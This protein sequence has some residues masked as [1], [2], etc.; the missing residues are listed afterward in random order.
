MPSHIFTRLG[1]WDEC[2][3]SN[4]ASTSAARCYAPAAGITGHWDEELHGLDYLVYAYLQKGGNKLAK[5]QCDYVQKIDD[6]YPVNFKVAYAFAA[7]PS[8]YLLENKL[9]DE[10]AGLKL[11]PAK[12]P[13]KNFPWQEAI[14]HFT[15]LMGCVH[16]GRMDSAEV[17]LAAL[18]MAHDSLMKQKDLYKA[19]QVQIQIN[20]AKAWMELKQGNNDE[21]IKLMNMAADMEDQTEKNPVTPCEVLPARELLGDMLLQMNKPAESLQAYEADLKRHPKR[22]NGVY[23]AGLAAE[24]SGKI[25]E[26][27][28]YYQQLLTF[29]NT[30]TAD[31]Q[32]LI[33]VKEFLKEH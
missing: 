16:I 13:W 22:F 27:K 33:K 4:L 17:E 15:R 5:E 6:V 12:F 21:A 7:I 8:R 2:I 26:A 32:E 14:V 28:T 31:R 24:K 29:T 20:T 19:T 18:N 1:L 9:W 23:G 3:T 25:R 11:H 30:T 10:A